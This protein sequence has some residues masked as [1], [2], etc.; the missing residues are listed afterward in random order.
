MNDLVFTGSFSQ[1]TH[2]KRL[3][4]ILV[5]TIMTATGLPVTTVGAQEKAP[6][7]NGRNGGIARP[8]VIQRKLNWTFA[9]GIR[10]LAVIDGEEQIEIRDAGGKDIMIKH[11]RRVAGQLKTDEYQAENVAALRMKS[12]EA[13]TLYQKY[14][15][16][17]PQLQPGGRLQ[18]GAPLPNMP[19][20]R[21][22]A[23]R[24]VLDDVFVDEF[25]P[26]RHGPRKIRFDFDDRKFEIYDGPDAA[27]RIK[28]S[29]TVE[30]KTV[31][32]EFKA[33]NIYQF[34]HAH[35]EL[36]QLY[37]KYTGVRAE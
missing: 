31:A 30:G 25:E 4:Q 36:Y 12:A 17:E 27:I 26:S 14:M 13:A 21:R 18:L 23:P 5:L 7:P 16:A 37:A 33:N 19:N 10:T 9:D 15:A 24:Q 34:R 22:G 8:E 29:S 1:K 3:F 35:P 20:V 6:I 11:T 28:I 32:E 2:M